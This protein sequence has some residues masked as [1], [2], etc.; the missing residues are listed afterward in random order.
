MNLGQ[1]LIYAEVG[2]SITLGAVI[3]LQQKG[4]GLS[5]TFGGGGFYQSKRGVEK[6][7]LIAT[8]ILSALFLLVGLLTIVVSK[9]IQPATT[10]SIN[11][12]T[13]P[14]TDESGA[15]TI[16]SINTI[17]NAVPTGESNE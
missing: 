13:V 1:I 14:L 5:S 3:L 4:T 17:P 7:L 15:P 12:E 11:I 10:E 8:I 6:G 9:T 16:P 2:I